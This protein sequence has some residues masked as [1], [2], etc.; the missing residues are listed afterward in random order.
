MALARLGASGRQRM[1][2]GDNFTFSALRR[3]SR[4]R[5]AEQLICFRSP[6]PYWCVDATD[7]VCHPLLLLFP[8][9]VSRSL[10]QV[11]LKCCRIA[12]FEQAPQQLIVLS[13]SHKLMLRFLLSYI[14]I[15]PVQY[16]S[17]ESSDYF[18]GH[19]RPL[20]YFTYY[21]PKSWQTRFNYH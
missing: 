8:S 10:P 9:P 3:R 13:I 17:S 2:V 14:Y 7:I 4:P 16:L 15:S 21:C 12:R 19:S 5:E 18:V 6:S 11:D 20:S 1:F